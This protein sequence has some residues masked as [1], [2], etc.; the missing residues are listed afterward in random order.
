M[1]YIVNGIE[2]TPETPPH[3]VRRAWAYELETTD[4]KQ[5]TTYLAPSENERCCLGILSDMA[6]KAG[7]IENYT[8]NVNWPDSV[9][10]NWAGLASIKAPLKE[11]I[12]E[13]KN[14]SSPNRNL[15]MANDSGY[16]FKQIA[17]WIKSNKVVI[18]PAKRN[19]PKP[20]A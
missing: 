5:G 4:K 9:V 6:V 8:K 16:T 15:G 20:K 7:V 3:L 11:D 10:T 19:R 14:Y 2:L 17:K 12:K 1:T 13:I 18:I